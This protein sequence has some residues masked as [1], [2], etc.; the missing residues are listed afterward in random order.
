MLN[1]YGS[2]STNTGV[3]P[4][5][6]TAEAVEINEMAGTITSSPGP[7]PAAASIISSVTVPLIGANTVAAALVGREGV[8]KVGHDRVE[9]AP[10]RAGQHLIEQLSFA[11]GRHGPGRKLSH[12]SRVKEWTFCAK[13]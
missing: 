2:M 3:A 5:R 12:P 4:T 8:F 6:D 1:E 11:G 7:M 13:E 9:A 10:L